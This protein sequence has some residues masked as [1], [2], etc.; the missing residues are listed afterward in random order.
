MTR[1]AKGGCPISHATSIESPH[2][3]RANHNKNE[4]AAGAS[5]YRH[6]PGFAKLATLRMSA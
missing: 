2:H 5:K 1:K 4:T 3:A 6:N